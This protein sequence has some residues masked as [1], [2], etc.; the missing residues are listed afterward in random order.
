MTELNIDTERPE[1]LLKT[2]GTDHI[3]IWGSNEE[4]TIEFYQDILGMAL[5]LKQPNLDDPDQTHLFFDTGDG[6]I[7]TF[8]VNDERDSARGQRPQTGS[9][10]HISYKIDPEEFGEITE[11]LDENGYGYNIFNRGIF[12]SIYTQDNNGLVVELSADKFNI[13]DDRRA[14]VLAKAHELRVEDGADY[15]KEEHLEQALNELGIEYDKVEL[16]EAST[17]V[18]V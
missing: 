11:A 15:A 5:V 10:H 16:P 7:L 14:E 3:T 4:D 1:S 8:F 12:H 2:R 6:R 9:V 13:P 17:G 18:G